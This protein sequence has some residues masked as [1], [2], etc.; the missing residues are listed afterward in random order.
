MTRWYLATVFNYN[1]MIKTIHNINIWLIK[2][3]FSR[4]SCIDHNIIINTHF[5]LNIFECICDHVGAWSH[6]FSYRTIY[7]YLPYLILE[8]IRKSSSK[9]RFESFFIIWNNF[10]AIFDGYFFSRWW[11]C[12]SHYISMFNKL[13]WKV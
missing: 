6:F 9:I 10:I 1:K 3:P 5:F 8:M 13:K 4:A 11:S 12:L 2:H 7:K